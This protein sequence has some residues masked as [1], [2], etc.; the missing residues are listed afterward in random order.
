[1]NTDD[2]LNLHY[3]YDKE[4]LSKSERYKQLIEVTMS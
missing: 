3:E 2:G 4:A 1:M